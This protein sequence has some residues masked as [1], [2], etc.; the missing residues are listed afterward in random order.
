SAKH[1]KRDKEI[2]TANQVERLI[3]EAMSPSN[4]INAPGRNRA[5]WKQYAVFTQGKSTSLL[6]VIA[7][8]RPF[9]REAG[10][11]PTLYPSPHP[12]GW[13]SRSGSYGLPWRGWYRKCNVIIIFLKGGFSTLNE[14]VQGVKQVKRRRVRAIASEKDHILNVDQGG[15]VTYNGNTLCE[16]PAHLDLRGSHI[17]INA[18]THPF[19]SY[20]DRSAL[21]AGTFAPYR[22]S[23][24]ASP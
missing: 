11:E 16:T 7:P 3:K 13:H 6:W 9:P 15:I 21:S 2:T 12:V 17:F 14:I 20:F 22:D 8:F 10:Y 1:E 18:C 5:Q 23:I 4:L 24:V 19:G